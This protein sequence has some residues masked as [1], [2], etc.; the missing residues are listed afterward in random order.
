V[1]PVSN[2][3]FAILAYMTKSV[4]DKCVISV[5]SVEHPDIP[6]VKK[7]VRG[8]IIIAGWCFEQVE[9]KLYKGT[10]ISCVLI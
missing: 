6:P 1:F 7:V 2:R 4:D 8:E 9:E 3:D 10:Y 5:T